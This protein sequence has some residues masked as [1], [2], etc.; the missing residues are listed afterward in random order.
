[1]TST[2]SETVAVAAAFEKLGIIGVLLVALVLAGLAAWYFRKDSIAAHVQREKE[3]KELRDDVAT[4]KQML[5][6]VKVAADQAGAKYDL[7][8]IG[9]LDDL[10][11]R[12]R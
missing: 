3:G 1:V 4:L 12:E 6:I 5:L 7:R 2:L 8:G 9:D 11:K 10:L